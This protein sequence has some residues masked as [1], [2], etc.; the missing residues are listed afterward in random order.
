MVIVTKQNKLKP[1][2]RWQILEKILST[3]LKMTTSHNDPCPVFERSY[4]DMI[5][6]NIAGSES[7]RYIRHFFGKRFYILL[8]CICLRL[9]RV[10]SGWTLLPSILMNAYLASLE[11]QRRS[12]PTMS[13][14]L[15]PEASATVSEH[16]LNT[17]FLNLAA[18]EE[19]CW[20]ARPKIL[21]HPCK[22][23]NSRDLAYSMHRYYFDCTVLF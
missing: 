7:N 22:D 8:T 2:W 17:M 21:P 9:W 12:T 5:Q 4:V 16:T 1:L 13:M 15:S 18:S 6:W 11:I 23:T 19:K 10:P 14:N 20:N 3:N